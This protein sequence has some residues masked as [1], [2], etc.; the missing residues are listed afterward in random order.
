MWKI[1]VLL[2]INIA[3]IDNQVE[4]LKMHLKK[5]IEVFMNI[6]DFSKTKI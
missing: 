1:F 5:N 2:I 6:L 3:I 4:K